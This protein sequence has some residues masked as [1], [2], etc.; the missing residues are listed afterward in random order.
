MLKD[1]IHRLKGYTFLNGAQAFFCPIRK[2]QIGPVLKTAWPENCPAF[3]AQFGSTRAGKSAQ[4]SLINCPNSSRYAKSSRSPS[5]TSG[6][7]SNILRAQRFVPVRP[8]GNITW[9]VCKPL[10]TAG[11]AARLVLH[12][13]GTAVDQKRG[14]HSTARGKMSEFKSSYYRLHI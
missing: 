2:D 1:V 9:C 8:P 4:P 11:K 12:F 7:C 5:K 13:F 3:R 14:I 10:E 6:R